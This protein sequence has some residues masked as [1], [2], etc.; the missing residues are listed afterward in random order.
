METSVRRLLSDRNFR[1]LV[2]GQTLTMFGDVALFLVLGIWIK[3]LTGSNGAAGSVFVALALPALLA[4]V[5]GFLV[6]RLP[7]RRVMIVNDIATAVVVLA[8]LGVHDPSDVWLIYVVATVYGASQ[9]IFFAARSGLLV[10]MLEEDRLGEANGLLE[11]LRQGLRVAGPL[12]GAAV[13]AFA[14]G[15]AVAVIDAATFFASAAFLAA[16]RVSEPERTREP[17]PLFQELSAGARHILRTPSLRLVVGAF[18]VA[19]CVVGALESALFALVDEG[20]GRPPEFIGVLGMVQGAGSVAGGLLSPHALRWLGEV[21]LIG[22]GC[23]LAGV[24]LIGSVLSM[25]A[26]V[27]VGS[28]LVGAGAAALFV[29]YMTLLQRRTTGGLQGRVFSAAEA[30]ITAPYAASIGLGAFLVGV[31]DYRLMYGANVVVL[32]AVGLFLFLS[33]AGEPTPGPEVEE[34]ALVGAEPPPTYPPIA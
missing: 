15:G 25:L 11:A 16:I 26:P 10:T 9:Q 30:V 3:D 2:M 1:L 8:L 18:A 21:R 32:A 5:G 12:V 17:V 33:R 13:F 6:D 29:G 14:G 27:L 22:A 4:P 7:R 34:P 23:A 19:V 31:I 24:G 28:L 20:L